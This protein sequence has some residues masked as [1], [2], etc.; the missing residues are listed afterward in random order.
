MSPEDIDRACDSILDAPGKALTVEF[1]GGDPL[2]RFD[3]VER[4]LD[5]ISMRSSDRQKRIQFV[6]A[7]TLHQLTPDICKSL[8]RYGVVLSTSID[9]P[10]RLHNK[11]RPIRGKNAYER[12]I[13]G[14][15]LAREHLGPGSV[16]AL[17]TTTRESLSYPEEIVD[18]YVKLQLLDISLRPLSPFGF[19]NSRSAVLGAAPQEFFTFYER[20]FERILHWNR[21]GIQIREGQA[22]IVLNKLLHSIDA[23]YVDLQGSCGAGTAVMVYNYDGFIYPSDEARMLAETGDTSLRLGRIGASLSELKAASPMLALAKHGTSSLNLVCRECTYGGFCSPD[24]VMAKAQFGRLDAPVGATDHCNRS[25]W[26]FDF[27]LIR[28]KEAD[29]VTLSMFRNWARPRQ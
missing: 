25:I 19:A 8:K 12:T 2:L 23:G 1:Q 9:G 15:A 27:L 13:E 26:L 28:L 29:P 24:P 22:A 11:N 14:I 3:L 18:E 7:S 4:A 20:A 21:E 6:V 5:R 10:Q 16:A 17:M